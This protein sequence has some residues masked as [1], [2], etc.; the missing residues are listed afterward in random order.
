MC[1]KIPMAYRVLKCEG[2]NTQYIVTNVENSESPRPYKCPLC[3]KAFYRIE[4]RT[5]HIRIHTGEKP[6]KCE[7][8]RCAK[9]F[10]RSD[11]LVRHRKTHLNP[12]KRGRKSKKQLAIEAQAL[13]RTI[14]SSM[15]ATSYGYE[16]KKSEDDIPN[17]GFCD[18]NS[19]EEPIRS[20]L[21]SPST[22]ESEEE[23]ITTPVL[24]SEFLPNMQEVTEFALSTRKLQVR[25]PSFSEVMRSISTEQFLPIPVDDQVFK[26]YGPINPAHSL[27]C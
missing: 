1:N 14:G 26:W 7:L 12:K 13:S 2:L 15:N 18:G 10:S 4:H 21:A 5:R 3:E 23:L 16:A 22:S 11:E 6:Y 9:S 17:I 19:P 8:N 27:Y 25:L 24:K 20:I